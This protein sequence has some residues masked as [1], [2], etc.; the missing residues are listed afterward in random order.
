MSYSD[1]SIPQQPTELQEKR[2][3]IKQL[4]QELQQL[5]QVVKREKENITKDKEN[6]ETIKQEIIQ[7][8]E[9]ELTQAKQDKEKLETQLQKKLNTEIKNAQNALANS[10]KNADDCIKEYSITARIVGISAIIL[11]ALDL[12]AII[13]FWVCHEK[14]ISL[15][16]QFQGLGAWALTLYSFPILIMLSIAITLFRHQKKLLDEVRHYSTEKR[17]IE[18]YS[19]LLEASQHAAAG[20]NDPQKS[21]EYV[22]ETFTT[23]RDRILNE[24]THAN[25]AGS[26]VE[27]EEYS[28]SL[29]PLIKV[30]SDMI[31]KSEVKK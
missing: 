11:I 24:P 12:G 8:L 5:K 18:L 15:L 21:A 9:T 3:Q 28:S 30:I 4:E 17:Q 22:H 16:G 19:G 7:K 26:A 27:K 20:L 13:H 29:E 10:L 14:L 1:N 31:A 2:S 25:T 23:I 6:N